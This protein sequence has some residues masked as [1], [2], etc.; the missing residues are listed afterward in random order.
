MIV[1]IKV[2]VGKEVL[3][4]ETYDPDKK[5]EIRSIPVVMSGIT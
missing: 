2:Q 4:V 5:R 3:L 1:R